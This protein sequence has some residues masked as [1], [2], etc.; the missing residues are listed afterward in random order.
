VDKVSFVPSLQMA[1]TM[2]NGAMRLSI[3]NC[4]GQPIEPGRAGKIEV[5]AGT[6]LA[7]PL[8]NWDLLT[9]SLV[10]TNNILLLEDP[11]ASLFEQ[12]YYRAVER[13]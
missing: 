8:A 12:R 3:G 7:L 11:Q 2:V 4:N 6:N 5:Y 9:N 1:G 13:P 10:L